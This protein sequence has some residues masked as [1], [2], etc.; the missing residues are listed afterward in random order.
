MFTPPSVV[1][2]G[3]H[4]TLLWV[5]PDISGRENTK[6]TKISELPI[7]LEAA[8]KAAA[9]PAIPAGV[10]TAVMTDIT[11]A[12]GAHARSKTGAA[13]AA[14]LAYL[15]WRKVEAP[16]ARA[17]DKEWFVKAVEKRNEDIKAFNAAVNKLQTRAKGYM[18]KTL[19]ADDIANQSSTDPVKAA[20]IKV[21]QDKLDQL[22][23]LKP[24]EWS[25]L[26]KVR[27]AARAGASDFTMLVK[28]V[29]GFEH[30]S[31][32]SMTSRYST[33]LTWLDA[34][35]G[36]QSVNG[37]EPLVDAIQTAGGID[38]VVA[39]QR[40]NVEG[41]EQAEAD[42]KA[43]AASVVQQTTDAFKA[44]PSLGTITMN[45]KNAEKGVVLLLCRDKG[46]TVEVVGQMPVASGKI[47]KELEKFDDPVLLPTKNEPEFVARVL[48][49]GDLIPEGKAPEVYVDGEFTGHADVEARTLFA[50]PNSKAGI[51]LMM[52]T[53]C[54]DVS[55]VVKARPNRAAVKLG[56]LSVPAAMDWK[57]RRTLEK[58][59][60]SRAQRRLINIASIEDDGGDMALG[61]SVVNEALREA[62]SPNAVKLHAWRDMS[63]D[64]KMPLDID[65]FKARFTLTV[66]ATDVEAF[67]DAAMR[68]WQASENGKKSETPMVL[69]FKAG[70][71][72]HSFGKE[73]DV[74]LP[75]TGKVASPVTLKF[76]ARALSDL[77]EKIVAQHGETYSFSAD[78][79]GMLAI[80]WT[81]KLGSYEVYQYA[82]SEKGAAISKRLK[83]F[84]F[85][86]EEQDEAQVA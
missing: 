43:I 23:T 77:F 25:K 8:K 40:G 59:T 61:W 47:D 82:Q 9:A 10:D 83:K 55:V 53:L 51:E 68:K 14:A 70:A 5:P 29:F 60:K 30:V 31:D 16:Y 73:P 13:E 35:F 6:M 78:E 81:D 15:V 54:A 32:A 69:T 71:I 12:R 20:E 46:G 2:N 66:K 4:G 36:K 33:V 72:I 21:E 39:E 76:S 80:S 84:Y 49:M 63:E 74:T 38:M 11:A 48:A 27:I 65:G 67:H 7:V 45:V 42:R 37:K 3:H 52:S 34:K 75:C 41:K 50:V 57:A 26:R 62:S 44:A 18:D 86:A 79:G 58:S 28:F 17:E 64:T 1:F 56:Q 85:E 19:G 22:S 24:N